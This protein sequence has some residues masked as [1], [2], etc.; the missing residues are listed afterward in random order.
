MGSSVKESSLPEWVSLI[1]AGICIRAT[2]EEKLKFLFSLFDVDT[3]GYIT[4]NELILMVMRFK[5]SSPTSPLSFI[6]KNYQKERL[7]QNN[8]Q[9]SL[10]LVLWASMKMNSIFKFKKAPQT[11]SGLL[12]LEVDKLH[13]EC[14]KPGAIRVL[15][16]CLRATVTILLKLTQ[17][18]TM[19]VLHE[20]CPLL[21]SVIKLKILSK[22]TVSLSDWRLGTLPNAS[23]Q[24]YLHFLPL[25]VNSGG[26]KQCFLSWASLP[27]TRGHY[28]LRLIRHQYLQATL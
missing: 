9:N 24:I 12:I 16:C 28:R 7:T 17:W 15:E 4:Q 19:E 13:I 10:L 11:E 6:F 14:M 20:F 2:Y 5:I 23:H 18:S 27:W 21:I 25:Q 22:L 1:Y 3:D 8:S 26:R